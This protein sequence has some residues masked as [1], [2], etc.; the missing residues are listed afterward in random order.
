[1]QINLKKFKIEFYGCKKWLD[2]MSSNTENIS[3][4]EPISSTETSE[5]MEPTETSSSIESTPFVYKKDDVDYSDYAIDFLSNEISYYDYIE[6]YNTEKDILL[7]IKQD[8]IVVKIAKLDKSGSIYELIENSPDEIVKEYVSI[9]DWVS[10]Y[11]REAAAIDYILDNVYIGENLVPLWRVIVDAKN[12]NH[13]E[14]NKDNLLEI[15][16]ITDDMLDEFHNVIRH[17]GT[18]CI[19]FFSFVT[20]LI[21]SLA[22]Y[23]K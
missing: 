20:I 6:S 18:L 17:I 12:E 1:M 8:D 16:I 21:V 7:F 2:K 14:E 23:I 5:I 13:L 22:I 19:L 15:N 4:T 3:S 9:I 11:K 10:A